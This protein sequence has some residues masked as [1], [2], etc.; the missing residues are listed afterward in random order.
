[1]FRQ[2]A[3]DHR[4]RIAAPVAPDRDLDDRCLPRRGFR[5]VSSIFND[6]DKFVKADPFP[7]LLTALIVLVFGPGVF[8]IDALIDRIIRRREKAKSGV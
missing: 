8:S 3:S 6:P 5:A 1:M 7:F 4:S 2:F